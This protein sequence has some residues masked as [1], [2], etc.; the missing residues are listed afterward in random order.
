LDGGFLFVTD[1]GCTDIFSGYEID[2]RSSLGK[3]R[4]PLPVADKGAA[5]F[6]SGRK[7]NRPCF[8]SVGFS[9]TARWREAITR[10]SLVQ[11]QPPQPTK[12]RISQEIRCFFF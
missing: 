4:I 2:E 5:V 3:P 10:R 1:V 9:E 12:H 7:S 11:I 6:R 8:L